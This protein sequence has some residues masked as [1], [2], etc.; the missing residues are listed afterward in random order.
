MYSARLIILC[1]LGTC[2]YSKAHLWWLGIGMVYGRWLG[3]GMV[4]GWYFISPLC[5][6]L[7]SPEL[8]TMASTAL[9]VTRPGRFWSTA[10]PWGSWSLPF[11]DSREA[12]S[13][14][15][16]RWW[17][18]L[19]RLLRLALACNSRTAMSA[20]SRITLPSTGQSLHHKVPHGDHVHIF[21]V[22]VYLV[23][24][25]LNFFTLNT[26]ILIMVHLVRLRIFSLKM[27]EYSISLLSL[28]LNFF[29]WRTSRVDHS[30]L[31]LLS[32]LFVGYLLHA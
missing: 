20:L 25:A 27:V 17:S 10:A 16:L 6:A 19:T 32:E 24:P 4:L 31:F 21:I 12:W 9:R 14:R 29:F 30:D 5:I 11:P 1:L 2:L 22:D 18:H 3:I 15:L 8:I 7:T 13:F 28:P 26:G 23:L